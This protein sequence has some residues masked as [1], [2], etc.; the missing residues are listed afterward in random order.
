MKT[1][2]SI[3]STLII[4]TVIYAQKADSISLLQGKADTTNIMLGKKEIQITEKNGETDIKV[5]NRIKDDKENEVRVNDSQ[6]SKD[7]SVLDEK[8]ESNVNTYRNDI[9]S[10]ELNTKTGHSSRKF[11]GHWDAFQIGINSYLSANKSTSLPL[12]DDFM[13]LNT[14][15]SINI[16]L[17][18]F[19]QSFG[20]I[21]SHFGA[22]TGLGFEFTNYVFDN[23]NTIVKDATGN[24]LSYDPGFKLD[25]SKLTTSYLTVP[26]LLEF[27]FPG[28]KRSNRLFI[29]G[30]VIG[31]IKL[32]AHTKY[33]YKENG[34]KQFKKDRNDFNLNTIRYGF[35]GRIGI[36]HF[37]IYGIYYPVALFE[38]NKGPE[39][40]PFMVGFSFDSI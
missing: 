36:K 12:N 24:I 8:N 14:N 25:K 26:L 16:N 10:D 2:I 3:I 35:I 9:T 6:E 4:S 27:Q 18:M 1:L 30:G 34:E 22:I 38:K 29:N 7:N 31:G 17:N 11:K 23:N 28:D 5:T 19:Q 39:L 21:G 13:S 33:K 20:I 37:S 15:K 40:Y 32:G